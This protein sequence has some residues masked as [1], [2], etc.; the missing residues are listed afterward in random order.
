MMQRFPVARFMKREADAMQQQD[1]ATGSWL[2][3]YA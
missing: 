1:L 2:L 3:E